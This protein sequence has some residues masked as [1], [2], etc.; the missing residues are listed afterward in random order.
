MI[1]NLYILYVW[2]HMVT[3]KR[4]GNVVSCTAGLFGL[5]QALR[6]GVQLL[7]HL[8]SQNP[9][10]HPLSREWMGMGEWDDYY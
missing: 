6:Q 8:F 7:L 9:I 2:Y 5:P 3:E 10:V 4:C 1:V